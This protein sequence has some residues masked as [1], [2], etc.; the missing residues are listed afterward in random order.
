[1]RKIF[2]MDKYV[3][4]LEALYYNGPQNPTQISRRT[5]INWNEL[6][7]YIDFLIRQQLVKEFIGSNRGVAYVITQRGITV[8][9]KF[10]ELK[11]IPSTME[12][13]ENLLAF[14]K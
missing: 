7:K 2:A 12:K 1:M 14:M 6:E 3:A 8:V 10:C 9:K 11:T 4:I 5:N 13:N